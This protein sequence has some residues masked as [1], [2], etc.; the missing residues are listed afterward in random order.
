MKIPKTLVGIIIGSS[1]LYSCIIKPKSDFNPYDIV[2]YK[3]FEIKSC[4]GI[5]GEGYSAY[6]V[7]TIPK[8]G[9]GMIP[10][11]NKH[12]LHKDLTRVILEDGEIKILP[13][14]SL[15]I[16]EIKDNKIMKLVIEHFIEIQKTD[17]TI[18]YT[19]KMDYF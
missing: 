16:R 8:E 4:T 14:S 12:F 9:I 7:E 1:L 11:N 3:T 6:I 17:T 10:V 5:I 2:D 18:K 15:K 13:E 19:Q